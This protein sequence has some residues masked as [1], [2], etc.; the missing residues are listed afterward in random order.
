MIRQLGEGS[1]MR[2]SAASFTAISSRET[3]S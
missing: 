1:S 2:T 3:Y